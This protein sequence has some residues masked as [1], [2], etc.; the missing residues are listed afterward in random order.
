[1][2]NCVFWQFNI[3][4]KVFITTSNHFTNLIAPNLTEYMVHINGVFFLYFRMFSTHWT[5]SNNNCHFLRFGWCGPNA[6]QMYC[7]NVIKHLE[8]W[9]YMKYDI[10]WF[11]LDL[12]EVDKGWAWFGDYHQAKGG[13]NKTHHVLIYQVRC[14]DVCDVQ[15]IIG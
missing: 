1:M 3:V 10:V 2:F 7:S 12:P 8:A 15:T 5:K 11:T 6:T 14:A 4:S 9:L 13:S